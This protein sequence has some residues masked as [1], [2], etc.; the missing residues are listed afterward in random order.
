MTGLV[1]RAHT[2]A[3]GEFSPGRE[4]AG[5]LAELARTSGLSERPD[6]AGRIAGLASLDLGWQG[7]MLAYF[8]VF[9]LLSEASA[10]ETCNA[11][12]RK[13]APGTSAFLVASLARS[14]TL[15]EL[16]RGLAEGYNLFHRGAFNR[17]ERSGG[18][19]VYIID[20]EGFPYASA[21]F[22]P[23]RHS[24]IESTL[25]YVH[26]IAETFS[27]GRPGSRR[28]GRA[29][30]GPTFWASGQRPSGLAH[31]AMPCISTAGT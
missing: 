2:P 25:V 24:F 20:D 29:L 30:C 19:T 6:V 13:L 15:G 16:L 28:G 22:E 7:R 18:Q 4:L 31:P 26:C 23:H 21:A 1:D 5:L 10:D 14:S 11:S 3:P 12:E 9:G 17:V 27:G 8:D